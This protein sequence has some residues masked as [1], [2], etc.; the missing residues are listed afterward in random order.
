MLPLQLK[1]KI[2]QKTNKP[3]KKKEE[4]ELACKLQQSRGKINSRKPF[5]NRGKRRG[6]REHKEI[7]AV[8]ELAVASAQTFSSN[9]LNTF[10]T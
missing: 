3:K 10:T 5:R 8:K 2:K 1:G 6:N 9:A 4:D 7:P